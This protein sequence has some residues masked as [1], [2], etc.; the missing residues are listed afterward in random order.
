MTDNSPNA[1]QPLDR[2][3][4]NPRQTYKTP[5]NVLN[6]QNLD[7]EQK[8]KLLKSWKGDVDSRLEAQAEGMGQADPLSAE[9]EAD[10]A[11]ETRLL[12]KALHELKG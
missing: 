7:K 4:D 9:E 1:D 3:A 5:A 12:D 8:V 10:L 2:E 11:N 6:D